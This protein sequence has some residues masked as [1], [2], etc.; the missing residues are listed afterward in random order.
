MASALGMFKSRLVKSDPPMV[1][2]FLGDPLKLGP[3]WLTTVLACEDSPD[4]KRWAIYLLK[5]IIFV[6]CALSL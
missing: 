4:Y 3:E 1:R 2:I 5:L 6:C